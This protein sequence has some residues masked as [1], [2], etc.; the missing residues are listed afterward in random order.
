MSIRTKLLLVLVAFA[1][2]PMFI[3]FVVGQVSTR[4][5]GARLTE[6]T[7]VELVSEAEARLLQYVNG[8]AALAGS[9]ALTVN[10][11]VVAQANAYAALLEQQGAFDDASD[12]M[13]LLTDD[14]DGEPPFPLGPDPEAPERLVTFDA[15]SIYLVADLDASEV[16]RDLQ[17]QQGMFVTY[18]ELRQYHDALI[19]AQYTATASGTHSAYPGHGG[20]PR[21]Y[22]PRERQ[23]YQM[24]AEG[25]SPHGPD[26]VAWSPPMRDAVTRRAVLAVSA[27]IRNTEGNVVAVTAAD[28][29]VAELLDGLKQPPGWTSEQNLFVVSLIGEDPTVGDTA[30]EIY[31]QRSYDDGET[32]WRH[33]IELETFRFDDDESSRVLVA[34]I[35][36]GQA[37]VVRGMRN[38][39]D[40][41]CA[42]APIV[43]GGEETAAALICTTPFSDVIAIADGI[44]ERFSDVTVSQLITNASIAVVVLGVV[45]LF[46]F[47]GSRAVS[48]PVQDLASTAARIA[49][50]DLDAR[51]QVTS[52]DE[53]GSLARTFNEMVPKL[54]DRMQLRQSLDLAMEVQQ[55]LLPSAAPRVPGVDVDGR[56]IYCDETGGDYYDFL[57]VEAIEGERLGVVVGDVT[58]HGIA[59]ALLMTTAR[60]LLRSRLDQPGSIAEQVQDINRHLSEGNQHGR[61][62]TF[63]YLMMDRVSGS[64]RWVLAGHDPPIL[65]EARTDTFSELGGGGGIPLGVDGT[66]EYDEL[67]RDGIETGDV[68]VIGT[69]GIWEARNEAAEM[70]GKDRLRDVIRDAHAGSASEICD[71]VVQAVV[72]FRGRTPQG[73][74]ITLVV[75][76]GTGDAAQR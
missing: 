64:L 7:Q 49:S 41:L 51:A 21:G 35:G 58:G 63:C 72:D 50:G 67:G 56:S 8:A 17:Q 20:Y 48:E 34:S 40:V 69:D 12:V 47:R 71:A 68:V 61:F 46:A 18:R 13:Y 52:G 59:A 4:F 44:D 26:G 43:S 5:V 14:M 11:M 65:Y 36:D 1:I 37:G 6:K 73:D 29:L 54:Q 27:P 2:L 19:F 32:D 24:A 57:L 62:M 30:L 74:D 10:L 9:E 38:G 25:M 60:A 31:A 16:T 76:K 55:S 33:S 75:L 70:F 15:M 53:L 39:R 3:A 66:W 45:V 28:V 23:W 42:Y 22:D